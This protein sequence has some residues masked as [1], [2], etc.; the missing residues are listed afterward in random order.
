MYLVSDLKVV[1]ANP[2]PIMTTS[3]PISSWIG[4]PFPN[5]PLIPTVSPTLLL[6]NAAVTTPTFFTVNRRKPSSVGD[7]AIP[8]GASPLPKTESSAN[9]PGI[10]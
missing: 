5:G 2:P 4:Q 10:D 7:E 8:S 9:W 3:W 1:K 6:C